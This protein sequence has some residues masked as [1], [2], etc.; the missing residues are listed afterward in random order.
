MTIAVKGRE[1]CWWI[2]NAEM[3]KKRDMPDESVKWVVDVLA[4]NS[5]ER[6]GEGKVKG[7]GVTCFLYK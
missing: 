6:R 3:E 2:P 5:V 1:K 4:E 7:V